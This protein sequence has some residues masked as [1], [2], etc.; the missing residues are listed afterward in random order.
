MQGRSSI[1]VAGFSK[2]LKKSGKIS[3]TELLTTY[4]NGSK[5]PPVEI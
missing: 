4:R 3:S 1:N 5:T 2:I